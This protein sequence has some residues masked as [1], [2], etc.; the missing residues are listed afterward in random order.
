MILLISA[1]WVAKISGIKLFCL[2]VC[3]GNT[4]VW[5][6]GLVLVLYHLSH[7]CSHFLLWIFLK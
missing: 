5:T 2:F 7:D 3:F 1:S 4:R 6:Q